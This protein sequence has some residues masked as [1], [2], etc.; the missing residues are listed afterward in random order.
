MGYAI[1]AVRTADEDDGRLFPVIGDDQSPVELEPLD[2]SVDRVV[3][4]GFEVSELVAGGWKHL[5]KLESKADILVTDAR[6]VVACTKF[7]KGGG[8]VGFGAGAFVALAAN[9]VSKARAAN[10]R[11]G[12]ML[13]GQ[14]RYAWLR[15][16][17]YMPRRGWGSKEELRLGVKVKTESGETRDLFLDV[18]LPKHVNSGELARAIVRRAAA[19][20]LAHTGVDTE[21]E[22]QALT[23]LIDA[24]RLPAP[25]AGKFAM[26]SMPRYFFVSAASAYPDAASPVGAP[27]AS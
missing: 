12:K 16:V 27:A 8:W 17:G 15:S 21:E 19:Y 23:E 10:R 4:E 7:T 14:V 3:S 18:S 6:F 5:M 1:F 26:Y 20:R 9:G 11:R 24:A 25:E 22:R 2:G 13:V